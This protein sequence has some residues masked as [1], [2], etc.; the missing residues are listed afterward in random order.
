MRL[1]RALRKAGVPSYLVTVKGA[2]HGEVG[3]VADAK[4]KAFFAKYLRGAA[5]EVSSPT[6]ERPR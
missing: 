4:V 5:V 6:A 1:H 2:E 3:G